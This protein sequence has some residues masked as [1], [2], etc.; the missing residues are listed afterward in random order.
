VS[1]VLRYSEQESIRLFL[2]SRADLFEGR[3]VLDYGCGRQPYRRLIEEAGG[4]YHGFDSPSFP[5]STYD[6]EGGTSN[7]DLLGSEGK[8]DVIVCT[9][10]L[11]YVPEPGSTLRGLRHLLASDGTLLLTGPTN[12]PVVERE[13]LWRFTVP[14][15][16]ALLKESGFEDVEANYRFGVQMEGEWWSIG[17]WAVA[18]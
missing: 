5:A 14:G 18:R 15:I 13:D 12:W 8:W 3:V 17:W 9:Q 11:Q 10:V 6:L 2:E 16:I 7:V 4:K 1:N